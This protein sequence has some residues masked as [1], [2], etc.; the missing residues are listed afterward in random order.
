MFG[1]SNYHWLNYPIEKCV[2]KVVEDS[3]QKRGTKLHELACKLIEQKVLLPAEDLTLNMYVNDAILYGMMPEQQLYYSKWFF[4]TADAILL[5]DGTLR[6]HDLKTGSTKASLHQLEI[7]AAYF[8]LEYDFIPSD[9]EDIELR[10]YQNNQTIIGHPG[11]SI[12]VPIMDKVITIN[13]LLEKL[14]ED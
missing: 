2:Q 9:F 12:L 3:A 8:C 4:G 10:I 7:Y 6:I 13:S 5:K 11:S 1:A 14:E